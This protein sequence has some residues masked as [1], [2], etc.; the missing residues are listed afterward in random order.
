MAVTSTPAGNAATQAVEGGLTQIN[1][2][3]D[4]RGESFA[5]KPHCRDLVT[6]P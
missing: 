5:Q 3:H 6:G 2:F 1:D 4:Y